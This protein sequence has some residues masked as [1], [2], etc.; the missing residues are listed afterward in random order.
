MTGAGQGTGAADPIGWTDDLH[1]TPLEH[2]E[3]LD[4]AVAAAEAD[5]GEVTQVL[6]R[7][8]AI[9][10]PPHEDPGGTPGGPDEADEDDGPQALVSRR[11]AAEIGMYTG[12]ALALVAVGGS[13]LR[14]WTAWDPG[15]RWAFAGLS[16][17][18]LIAV[19]LFVRLP[20]RRVPSD[21]R[22]R[23]VSA[24]LTAGVAVATI[25]LGVAIGATQGLE[26]A[27]PQP[28]AVPAGVVVVMTLVNVI[29]RT[30]VSEVVLLM[31][32][33]VSAWTVVPPGRGTLAF[34]TG[35]GVVWM[36]LGMRWARGRRTAAVAGA[37]LALVASV[38]LAVG[39]WTWP[40][41]AG[42][43]AVAI[44]G[45]GAFM[46]GRANSWLAL[47]AGASTALAASVAG[48]V[49]GPAVAL[50]VGGLATMTVSWIALRSAGED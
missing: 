23:A 21:Q 2:T 43:G 6:S 47:G 28:T 37:G 20:W 35:L 29:A 18:A 9:G 24:L 49:V 4:A 38:G 25:G 3:V 14:G 11:V 5:P 26:Q 48:D 16:A 7:R 15:L 22:R 19:G 40:V 10:A 8:P 12:A 46:R 27:A 30:P 31:A 33:A 42:L 17:V 39:P 41:R 50:L 36:V 44:L 32:V 13:V 45:L 34:L 1:P